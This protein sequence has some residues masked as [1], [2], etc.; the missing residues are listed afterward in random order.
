M[1]NQGVYEIEKTQ[2]N[3]DFFKIARSIINSHSQTNHLT[4]K[5]HCQIL[6]NGNF[7]K[8]SLEMVNK[9]NI[10]SSVA[11]SNS[12]SS[13]NGPPPRESQYHIWL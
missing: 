5:Y 1:S 10:F 13:S 7:I 2:K 4:S 6:I 3:Y 8:D 12:G 9:F 11:S